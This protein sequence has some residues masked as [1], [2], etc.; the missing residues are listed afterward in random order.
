MDKI[1]LP[2]AARVT[3]PNPVTVVCTQKPD[4]GTNLATVSWWTY[5]S[6]NPS[7]I[8]YAMAKTSFS[9]E[10]VRQHKKLVLTV[11]G[12]K[13]AEAV[14]GCGST[15]GRDTDKIE[16]FGIETQTLPE[17]EIRVP[18]HS[19]LAIVCTL[20]EFVETGDHYLYI[21]N[22][23]QVYADEKE[24]ALFAWNGYS[25]IAPAKKTQN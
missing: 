20:K 2:K 10:M 3:S 15:T 17:S 12:E 8:A 13:I 22:V 1:T 19:A 6:Y 9:G 5:L 25:E 4:G 7:M 24:N 14:L 11:P 18:L 21:C 16:K 23:E